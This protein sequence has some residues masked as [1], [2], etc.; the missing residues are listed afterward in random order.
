MNKLSKLS[1]IIVTYKNDDILNNCLLSLKDTCNNAPQIIVVDNDNST[2]TKSLCNAFKN[3]T[4]IASKENLGFAGGNNLAIPYCENEFILLLN[5]DTIIHTSDSII[6]LIDFMETHPNCGVAQG[7]M[8]LPRVNNTLGGCGSFITPF[9]TLYNTGFMTPYIKEA[10]K[11]KKCFAII[12]AFMLTKKSAINAAGGFLF[13]NHFKSYYE[14]T[15]FCHRILIS[16]L[17][18]WYVPTSPIDHLCGM[19]SA[20]FNRADI[21]KQY[22]SNILFSFRVNLCFFYRIKLCTAFILTCFCT[23]II[24]LLKGNPQMF[25]AI[26]K[27][28]INGISKQNNLIKES[29]NKI[30]SIRKCDD[31][32]IMRNFC[33]TYTIKSF[34]RS[35]KNHIQN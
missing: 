14:E 34:L 16:N 10:E 33:K 2:S 13:Y 24:H 22:V 17:E 30:K 9:G 25:S 1:I 35:L 12:G 26:N 31:K 15:D 4:Y 27:G 32:T 11:P 29:R 3:I 5:N 7:T 28:I 8:L 19:T 6:Q 23:S 20:L 21:M 18:V